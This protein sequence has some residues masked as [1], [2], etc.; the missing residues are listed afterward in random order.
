[1]NNRLEK[2][3]I[4]SAENIQTENETNI[5]LENIK[6]VLRNSPSQDE[7]NSAKQYLDSI[8]LLKEE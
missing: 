4:L 8:K 3:P 5:N 6:K 2:L 7:I 1:M